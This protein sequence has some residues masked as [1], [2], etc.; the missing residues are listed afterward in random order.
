MTRNCRN[1][2]NSGKSS[3]IKPQTSKFQN[4]SYTAYLNEAVMN[5]AHIHVHLV[6]SLILWY[7][8]SFRYIL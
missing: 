8:F 3:V 6:I 1:P 4:S 5:Y 2:E 7:T